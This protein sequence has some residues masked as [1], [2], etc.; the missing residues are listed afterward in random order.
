MGVVILLLLILFVGA[1]IF[2]IGALILLLPEL[3]S[4]SEKIIAFLIKLQSYYPQGFVLLHL[5]ESK[6]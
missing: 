3:V 5:T 1:G 2:F 4:E 6:G